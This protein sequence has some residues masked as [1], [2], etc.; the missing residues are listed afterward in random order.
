MNARA[1][2]QLFFRTSTSD[3]GIDQVGS[4]VAGRS[5]SSGFHYS[6]RKFTLRI[7]A[8]PVSSS[9]DDCACASGAIS[10][11]ICRSSGV[12]EIDSMSLVSVVTS[13][14]L[15]TALCDLHEFC[16]SWFPTFFGEESLSC[17][18]LTCPMT[19]QPLLQMLV[20]LNQIRHDV[21]TGPNPNDQDEGQ[22]GPNPGD[23]A[24]SL[25]LPSLVV[26]AGPNLEHMNLKVTNFSTQP[27]PEQID[28]GF[29]TTAYPKVQENLKLTVEESW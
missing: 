29:T 4:G 2:A 8:F 17:L 27:H 19:V 1:D 6:C 7:L 3:E 26:H 22:A 21:H 24:A 16:R 14:E 23:A 10:S 18:F 11:S 5:S 9:L 28:E 25:S 13:P 15:H 20:I 12:E